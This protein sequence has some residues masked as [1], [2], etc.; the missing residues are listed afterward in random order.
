MF[1]KNICVF[2]SV[3]LMLFLIFSCDNLITEGSKINEGV[4][5]GEYPYDITTEEGLLQAAKDE[6]FVNEMIEDVG[7]NVLRADG[8]SLGDV[9]TSGLID[10]V[11]ALLTAQYYVGLE[12]ANFDST[13]ADV[14][15]SGGIDIVDA[16]LIAQYYVGLIEIFP[17]EVMIFP[18]PYFEL[19][20]RGKTGKISDDEDIYYKD[21]KDI[22]QL[23]CDYSQLKDITGIEYLISLE[24][25]SINSDSI[26]DIS[27]IQN[28]TS[29]W[30]LDVGNNDMT[31]ISVLVNLTAL[32]YLNLGGNR[33]EDLTPLRNCTLMDYLYLDDNQIKTLDGL[34][35][36]TSL[37][38]L[39]ARN[40]Q[41]E[42]ISALANHDSLT[43][44]WLRYNRIKDLTGLESP[45][46]LETMD[47]RGNLIEDISILVSNPAI[48]EGDLVELY[49]NNLIDQEENIQTLIDRGV[50]VGLD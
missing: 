9:D 32:E 46:S 19:I 26:V 4:N 43:N 48:G 27:P 7:G 39:Y 34:E 44:F 1:K 10:I 35:N 18:D 13:V 22:T 14:D 12:P 15:A 11:D 25:L 45:K 36:M 6:S 28:L 21:V 50:V 24:Q 8:S 37:R 20:M 42:D 49:E 41:I 5:S 47:L 31:D 38:I 16:L 30:Y 29:L 40:N 3:I 2:L 23:S 33:I 17:G